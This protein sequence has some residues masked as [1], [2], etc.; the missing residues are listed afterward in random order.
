[1]RRFVEQKDVFRNLNLF[2]S[3]YESIPAVASSRKTF[4]TKYYQDEKV[5]ADCA[6]AVRPFYEEAFS[7]LE[8]AA[9]EKDYS[10]D[11]LQL[12]RD[13]YREFEHIFSLAV[14]D[15]RH[16]FI[17]VIPVADRPLMLRNC[18]L[19]IVKQCCAFSYG[20]SS[21]KA[22]AGFRK[23][24]VFVFDDSADATNQVNIREI[25]EETTA[26]GVST[27]YVG[28]YQQ[29]EVLTRIPRA[30][31]EKLKG[32]VGDFDGC[33]GSHKGASLTRNIASL[34]IHSRLP[35]FG[36]NSLIWFIDSDEE[37]AV[38]IRRGGDSV[39]IPFINYFY[40]LDRIFAQSDV[41]VVTGKVV[42][43]PPVTPAVMINSFLD[44]MIYFLE[45]TATID[46]DA[47]C[48][49]HDSKASNTFSADY[50]DMAAL[51]G[52]HQ[53]SSPKRYLCGLQ[54]E[55]SALSC[56]RDFAE[57]TNGF[58]YGLHPTRKQFF[59]HRGNFGKT[60]NARTVYTGNYIVTPAGLQH[61]IPFAALGLRMAGPTFG[62]LLR[63]IIKDR[64]VS[65]N[66]PLLHRRTNSE[67]RITEFRSGVIEEKG[68]LDLSAEFLRQ[69][70]GDVMLFSSEALSEYGYPEKI[71][72]PAEIATAV[73]KVQNSFWQ[74]YKEH[75]ALTAEKVSRA[76]ELISDPSAWWN[77]R[78]DMISSVA[79]LMTFISLVEK[80]FGHS[81][82][83][84]KTI[85][86]QIAEGSWT[87]KIIAALSTYYE[88]SATW[89]ELLGLF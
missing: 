43:D 16:H 24:S 47:A 81:S 41:E 69:F 14:T 86:E 18:L 51:F 76:H 36:D 17:I 35:E 88:D 31:R 50:H 77:A 84:M 38:K 46:P 89:N 56:F 9:S 63:R 65:A 45:Q 66:L 44:D 5:G 34:Y 2:Y 12:Q 48:I 3:L 40:W 71:F 15:L 70:W 53:P 85:D 80:N 27:F 67:K 49:F 23:I 54:K 25:C 83:V 87:K 7:I 29:A 1:M 20:K 52:Y 72:M 68:L 74:K 62:R 6:E 55:H 75:Q 11:I 82:K 26:A 57:L 28:I 59:F 33:P 21:Q 4:H 10:D 32:L 42:G 37:F 8:N 13:L 30:L 61:F 39:S 64:F 79:S 78:E 22:G 73:G 19:S 60:D 58:F